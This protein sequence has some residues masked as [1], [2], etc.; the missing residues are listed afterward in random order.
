MM[1]NVSETCLGRKT[2][3][4]MERDGEIRGMCTPPGMKIVRPFTQ[5][6]D[7]DLVT[8]AIY[9]PNQTIVRLSAAE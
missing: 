5:R 1:N 4:I 2:A 3:R 7:S 9:V 8:G 6:R